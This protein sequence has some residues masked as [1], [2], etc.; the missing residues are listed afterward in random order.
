VLVEIK[1][2]ILIKSQ[3]L[4]FTRG[5][6]SVT[7]DD[8]ATELGISKKTIYHHFADKGTLVEES[9]IYFLQKEK[10]QEEKIFQ[11]S[12]NP[13]DEIIL[14]TQM[15]REML[16]NI[17]PSIFHDL[18]KFYPKVWG[19]YLEHKE[20]FKDDVYRNLMQGIKDGY[21]REDIQPAVMAKL[22]IESVDMAFNQE[23][24]PSK[25]FNIL[26]VQLAFID[27]FIR[28]LVTEKGL[29]AYEAIK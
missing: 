20:K 5:I 10:C 1:E 17:N 16:G 13:I 8:I 27:H 7:M 4:Y 18:Q 25:E 9:T 22:R 3:E 24:F 23:I 12:K 14:N 28:G 15:M 29:K 11:Q 2:R 19:H 21:Y 26:D 6:R